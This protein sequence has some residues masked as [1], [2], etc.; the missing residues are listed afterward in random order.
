MQAME[1]AREHAED[2]VA[3]FE[4]EGEEAQAAMV[5]VLKDTS[6]VAANVA[7]GKMHACAAQ[8]AVET[9]AIEAAVA[10]MRAMR[11]DP[12]MVSLEA[13]AMEAANVAVRELRDDVIACQASVEA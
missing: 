1:L 6:A 2:E 12:A 11:N 13:V 9:V 5:R 4:C 8:K 7:V 10:A 3:T